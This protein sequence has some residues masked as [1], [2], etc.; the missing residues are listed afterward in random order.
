MPNENCQPSF[1]LSLARS[2]AEAELNRV[3]SN[4]GCTC[5]TPGLYIQPLPGYQNIQMLLFRRALHTRYH[6]GNAYNEPPVASSPSR[7]DTKNKKKEYERSISLRALLRLRTSC[8]YHPNV[9][10]TVQTRPTRNLPALVPS[11]RPRYDPSFPLARYAAPTGPVVDA[12]IRG[13]PDA[14]KPARRPLDR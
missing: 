3:T 1:S 2:E 6:S 7:D 14:T 13:S 11:S 5:R 12:R 4:C 8:A 9:E 10:G